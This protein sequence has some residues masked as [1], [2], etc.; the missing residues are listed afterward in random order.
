MTFELPKKTILKIY[1]EFDITEEG[2][3]PRTH[4]AWFDYPKDKEIKPKQKP[5]SVFKD[6]NEEL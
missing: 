1:A 6:E 5:L 4:K 3:K 2:L